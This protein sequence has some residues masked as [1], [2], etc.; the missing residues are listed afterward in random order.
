V[1]V[2]D[3]ILVVVRIEDG[4]PGA[5]DEPLVYHARRYLRPGTDA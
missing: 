5:D 3:A 1:H 4:G 2:H